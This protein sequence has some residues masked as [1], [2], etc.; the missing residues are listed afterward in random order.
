MTHVSPSETS[1]KKTSQRH[2]LWARVRD[3]VG[4]GHTPRR[5]DREAAALSRAREVREAR[6]SRCRERRANAAI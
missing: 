2:G 6:I 3:V 5:D 4:P 1:G